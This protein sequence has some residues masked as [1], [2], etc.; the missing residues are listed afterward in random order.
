MFHREC[1]TQF[2]DAQD[3]NKCPRCNSVG[4]YI[5]C[6]SYDE[7]IKMLKDMCAINGDNV[8]GNDNDDTTTTIVTGG[9]DVGDYVGDNN[10]DDAANDNNN[11]DNGKNND[12]INND[13]NNYDDKQTYNN[14]DACAMCQNK[15]VGSTPEALSIN[16]Y[17]KNCKAT[18]VDVLSIISCKHKFNR[19]CWMRYET[20]LSRNNNLLKYPMCQ[21]RRAL[22]VKYFPRIHRKR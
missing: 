13:N 14:E 15:F 1:I 16:V 22:V 4:S 12:K 8:K 6:Q 5:D 7:Q 10:D 9:R 2:C 17:P 18:I 11:N 19:L 3:S 20:R 21:G